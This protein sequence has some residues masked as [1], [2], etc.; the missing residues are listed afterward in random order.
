MQ[1]LGGNNTSGSNTAGNVY[2]LAGTEGSAGGSVKIYSTNLNGNAGDISFWLGQPD[3][4]HSV[5]LWTMSHTGA[6]F[7]GN[8][9]AGNPGDVLVSAGNLASPSWGPP[10]STGTTQSTMS[11]DMQVVFAP[12]R[13]VTN[14]RQVILWSEQQSTGTVTGPGDLI[15]SP[16]PSFLIPSLDRYVPCANVVNNSTVQFQGV[17]HV[18]TFGAVRISL[19]SPSGTNVQQILNNFTPSGTKG[20][21]SGW[22]ITYPL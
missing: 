6:L 7:P 10:G 5:P 4:P 11:G 19:I 17:A 2:I 22:C 16:I 8:Q 15:V 1:I 14:G 12:L 21:S 18:D 3:I 9:G 13:Y 20:I